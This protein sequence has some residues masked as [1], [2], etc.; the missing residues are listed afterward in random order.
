MRQTPAR[1]LLLASAIAGIEGIVFF[2]LMCIAIWVAVTGSSFGPADISN[3][4]AVTLEII[5]FAGLSA[6]MCVT[7]YGMYGTR[8]WARAPFILMQLIAMGVGYNFWGA[9]VAP[10]ILGLGI[11]GFVI[12]LLPATTRALLED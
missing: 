3:G 4:T 11:V 9:A 12:A 1:P 2:V 6:G 8:R 7:A 5:I 10:V